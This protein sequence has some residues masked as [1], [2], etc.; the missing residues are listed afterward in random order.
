MDVD[1][2][3]IASRSLFDR[4]YN[5]DAL[6]HRIA[7]YPRV[8][9][10]KGKTEF[11]QFCCENV[12][13]LVQRAAVKHRARPRHQ[14][15]AEF[16]AVD[17]GHVTRGANVAETIKRAFIDRKRQGK[18]VQRRIIFGACRSHVGIRVAFAAIVEPQLLA[19]RRDTV[20]I[21]GIAAGQK[22]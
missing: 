12:G 15:T 1:A 17:S 10:S 6:A 21:V 16:F 22:A 2:F 14:Q 5:I 3:D 11:C 18:S 19:I 8:G 9:L 7:G 4:E 13:S 20:L